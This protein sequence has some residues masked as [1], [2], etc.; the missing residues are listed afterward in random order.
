FRGV[1]QYALALVRE[2]QVDRG[3]HLFPDRRVALDLLA[4]GLYRSMRAEE[5]V[6]QGF[7]FTEQTEQQVF[8]LDVRR[9]ELTGFIARKKYDASGFLR[10]SLEHAH[11]FTVKNPKTR[12]ESP[13]T[14]FAPIMQLFK[15]KFKIT[16][17]VPAW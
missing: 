4:N 13:N 7:V 14:L 1:R 9:A 11:L 15:R 2:G 12:N 6:G 5:A 17:Y 8:S 10:V 3:R 16:F